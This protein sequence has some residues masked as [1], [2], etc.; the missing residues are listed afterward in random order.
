[1]SSGNEMDSM[2]LEERS[3]QGYTSSYTTNLSTTLLTSAESLNQVQELFQGFSSVTDAHLDYYQWPEISNNNNNIPQ[4][5]LI[6]ISDNGQYN[7]PWAMAQNPAFADWTSPQGRFHTDE[8]VPFAEPYSPP[9]S[10]Q[11]LPPG[12]CYNLSIR[13]PVWSQSPPWS[14]FNLS[15]NQTFDQSSTNNPYLEQNG[16]INPGRCSHSPR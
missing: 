8:V 16:R 7:G 3:G 4:T 2:D 10:S 12:N 6:I 5:P 13:G 9:D 15:E 14:P 11:Q 1:M